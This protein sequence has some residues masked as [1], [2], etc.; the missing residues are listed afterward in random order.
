MTG[1]VRSVSDV[2]SNGCAA[3]G[4]GL[5][6]L[7]GASAAGHPRALRR[8]RVGGEERGAQAGRLIG[9]HAEDAAA[10]IQR[11]RLARR[12]LTERDRV[13]S[14]RPMGFGVTCPSSIASAS[15]AQIVPEQ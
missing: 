2:G 13:P 14:I 6:S 7:V 10:V 9:D 1:T 8:P 5:G 11:E 3:A 12:V 15:A 4:S